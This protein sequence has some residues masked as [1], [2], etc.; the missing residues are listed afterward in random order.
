MAVISRQYQRLDQ[1]KYRCVQNIDYRTY[2]RWLFSQ[3]INIMDLTVSS[4]I[5][6]GLPHPD[7]LGVTSL[8]MPEFNQPDQR[9]PP[10]R[11]RVGQRKEV[12]SKK[13]CQLSSYS[14]Q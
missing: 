13:M 9:R 3:L 7:A 10:I 4:V 6:L 5:H 12:G 1:G 11:G 2:L 8:L 14:S